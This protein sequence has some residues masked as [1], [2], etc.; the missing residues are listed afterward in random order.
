MLFIVFFPFLPPICFNNV[1]GRRAL[2]EASDAIRT[3][4]V[5]KPLVLKFSRLNTFGSKV[6]FSS[7]SDGLDELHSVVRMCHCNS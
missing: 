4:L 1:R 2:H 7:V 6:V 3:Q 5:G